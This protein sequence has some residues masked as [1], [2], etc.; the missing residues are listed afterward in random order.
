MLIVDQKFRFTIAMSIST[1]AR[2]VSRIAPKP[3]SQLIH[4]DI[5]RWIRLP[6]I[7]PTTISVSAT[8]TASRTDSTA[9]ASA[10]PTQ[11]AVISHTFSTAFSY[12]CEPH[13][14]GG[15]GHFAQAGPGPVKS[16]IGKRLQALAWR[17]RRKNYREIGG[18]PCWAQLGGGPGNA[19][20]ALHT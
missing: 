1:P 13:R 14:P 3:A 11:R 19:P 4:S 8:E 5:C 17:E 9:A 15:G 10:R 18:E 12:A 7:A 2:K 20:T 6:A 16:H